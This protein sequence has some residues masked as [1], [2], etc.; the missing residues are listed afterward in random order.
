[1]IA[2]LAAGKIPSFGV[3]KRY[4]TPDGSVLWGDL[5]VSCVR[6]DDGSVRN[7]IAQIMDVSEQIQATQRLA[8]SEAHYRL[9]AENASD[10]V[11]QA[12]LDGAVTWV[13]PSVTRTLGW[14][15]EDLLGTQLDDL[16]HPGDVIAT[17]AQG[18]EVDPEHEGSTSADGSVVRIRGRSGEYRW[19]SVFVTAMQ[20]ESGVDV[21]LISSLRD[22]DDLVLAR[23]AAQADRAILRATVDSLL[24][25]QVRL[26][27]VRDQSGQIVD[28]VYVDANPAACAYNGMDY[29]DLVGTR[30]LDLLPGHAG[31]GLMDQY[32]QVLQSGEP[33]VLDDFVYAQELM[34]GTERHYDIRTARVDGGLTYTWRDVTDRH[35]AA[36]RL[37]ES[38]EQYRL[39]AENASDVVMRLSP[40]RRFEWVSGS[41]AG[42]LGWRVP[43]LVEHVIDEF[44]HPE[45]LPRFQQGVADAGLENPASQ[46]IRFR[47]PY[48]A[49]RWLA[50]RTRMKVDEND[51]PVSMIG[52]LVDI[53]DRKAAEAEER[54]RLQELERF[55]RLTV[56]REL[57]MIELK[58]EIEFLK[59]SISAERSSPGNEF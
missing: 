54:Q 34:G 22:V 30:L 9:L 37:A 15:P 40:D 10:F 41:V 25:P 36:Q 8:E 3:R 56:G 33:L 55:Q 21:A 38:E 39:L 52:G 11:A 1:M 24:D 44:I 45:D 51:T 2:D 5:S 47:H 18:Q 6:N 48:G 27:P 50:C 53:S 4:L 13:S 26:D 20:D 32:R 19:M 23:E 46:E 31:A 12:S 17:A 16:V 7:F 42:V 49:Y 29:E 35:L 57:K 43:D 28:F 58:K 14:A 59:K